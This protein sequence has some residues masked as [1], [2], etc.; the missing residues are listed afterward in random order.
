MA[1]HVPTACS[2]PHRWKHP[3]PGHAGRIGP[4]EGRKICQGSPDT[5]K[6]SQRTAMFARIEQTV[7]D[8][9]SPKS[10][11]SGDSS[12]ENASC[13]RRKERKGPRP[14]PL[15]IRRLPFQETRTLTPFPPSG[16][17]IK[18]SRTPST[19]LR[20]VSYSCSW[21]RLKIVASAM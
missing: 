5:V 13:T 17:G 8:S 19:S 9:N 15:S 16:F 14:Q 10:L 4:C 21:K 6:I 20:S 11:G 3:R 7:L 12:L 1:G 18:K 2:E